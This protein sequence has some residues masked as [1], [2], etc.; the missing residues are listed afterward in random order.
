MPHGYRHENGYIWD[1]EN[2]RQLEIGMTR[3][4]ASFWASILGA[5]F[6]RAPQ[7]KLDEKLGFE[8]WIVIDKY[9]CG[10]A[11][12]TKILADNKSCFQEAVEGILAE[13][14]M[15]FD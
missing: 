14:T 7:D 9:G 15:R 6:K 8:P 11:S 10:A 12:G 4:N 1:A 5:S 2:H 3:E 13:K